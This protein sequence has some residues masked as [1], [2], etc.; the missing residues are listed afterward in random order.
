M[1]RIDH[2]ETIRLSFTKNYEK[3]KKINYVDCLSCDHFHQ[4][5]A[6]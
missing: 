1:V 4:F 2:G 3:K 5:S 6:N